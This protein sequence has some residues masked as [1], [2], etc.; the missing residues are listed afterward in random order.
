MAHASQVR[1]AAAALKEED[2]RLR[3][4]ARALLRQTA[5][6]VFTLSREFPFV[7]AFPLHAAHF[8]KKLPQI[9]SSALSAFV[10]L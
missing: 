9:C 3:L 5:A 4:H 10:L 7:K 8:S 1:L 2:R 6:G